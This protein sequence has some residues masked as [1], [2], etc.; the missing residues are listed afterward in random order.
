[1]IDEDSKEFIQFAED[2]MNDEEFY[3]EFR[4]E[5]KRKFQNYIS[6]NPKEIRKALKA[7]LYQGSLEHG[8]PSK[9]S[10]EQVNKE[11]EMEFIDIF[12][13]SLVGLYCKKKQDEKNNRTAIER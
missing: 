10:Q 2:L 9:Y 12:G 8:A 3:N 4:L 13:W 11:L 6:R 7:K 5:C 1:M